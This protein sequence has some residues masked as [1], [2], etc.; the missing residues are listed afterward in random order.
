[1]LVIIISKQ[2]KV[3]TTRS[4]IFNLVVM[5]ESGYEILEGTNTEMSSWYML[6]FDTVAKGTIDENI[7]S[8]DGQLKIRTCTTFQLSDEETDTKSN[9]NDS[10][11]TT[12]EIRTLMALVGI[13][14]MKHMIMENHILGKGAPGFL[15]PCMNAREGRN[16]EQ[17]VKMK[18]STMS[19]R[20]GKS[21]GF[22]FF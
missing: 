4:L 3:V 19:L 7:F 8:Y 9:A 16:V 20:Y 18:N 2:T 17:A 11:G 22:K 21:C 14:W 1:M 5:Q 6:H 13:C 12:W 10:R 15:V